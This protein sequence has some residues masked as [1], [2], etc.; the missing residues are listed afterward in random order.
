MDVVRNCFF[1]L[2]MEVEDDAFVRGAAKLMSLSQS[3]VSHSRLSFH[4]SRSS[5]RDC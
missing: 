5:G 4:Q 3:Y 2:D 1:Q